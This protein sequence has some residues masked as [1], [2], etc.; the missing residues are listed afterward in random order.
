[1]EIREAIKFLKERTET[2][3]DYPEVKEYSEALRVAVKTLEKQ[4]P[5]KVRYEEVGYERYGHV[6]VYACICPSC[7]LEIVTFDDGVVSEKCESD[8]VGKKFH[9]SM[10]RHAY[11]G[12]NKYCNRCG[13]KLDWSEEE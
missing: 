1:M 11:I 10:V 13:Q 12:L 9:S 4:I 7:D 8:D 6:D 5:K 3:N 2:A